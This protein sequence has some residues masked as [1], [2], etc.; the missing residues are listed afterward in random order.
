MKKNILTIIIMAIVLIN[1]I[2]TGVVIFV[3]VPQAQRTQKVIDKVA[4]IID[5]ELGDPTTATGQLSIDDIATYD[6]P[7]KLTVPLKS[8][9][10]TVHY[11]V[12]PVAFSMDKTNKDY[13]VLSK[14]LTE[15]NTAIEGIF[16][17]AFIKYTMEDLQNTANKDAI[18][19]DV[20][21]GVKELFQ[22]DFIINV[23]FGTILTQ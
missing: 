11:A 19:A 1:T 9:G 23:S 18:R 12:F 22:S 2:L 6:M 3:I 10:D 4:S 14:K 13:T 15:Y 7:E 20:L 8:S 17:D 21:K 16:Q 5:L